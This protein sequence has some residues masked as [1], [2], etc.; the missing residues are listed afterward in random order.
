MTI[1]I[2]I[3]TRGGIVLASDSEHSYEGAEIKGTDAKIMTTGISNSDGDSLAAAAIVGAGYT[4]YVNSIRGPITDYLVNVGQADIIQF[5]PDEIR[6][7]IEKTLKAFY[8]SHV[9][10]F[11]SQDRSVEFDLLIAASLH[12]QRILFASGKTTIRPVIVS[13]CI[14]YG[15]SYGTNILNQ[16]KQPKDVETAVMQACYAVL[17]V[18]ETVRDC[19]RATQIACLINNGVVYVPD[20]LIQE[21]E[22]VMM[23]YSDWNY[24]LLYRMFAHQKDNLAS[25]GKIKDALSKLRQSI[26]ETI[27]LID[28]RR[29]VTPAAIAGVTRKD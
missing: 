2:G 23:Q 21:L 5:N 16:F 22:G 19:G 7:E 27:S 13:E 6:R 8:E 9:M 18:K 4:D 28:H 14:G 25:L 12:N 1:A 26:R 11:Y 15:R 24:D 10:P 29:E 3:L 20:D 17:R